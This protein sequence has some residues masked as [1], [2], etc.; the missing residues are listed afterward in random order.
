MLCR[1]YALTA[2]AVFA[3]SSIV[4]AADCGDGCRQGCGRSLAFQKYDCSCDGC[5]GGWGSCGG[6]TNAKC[7][8]PC[9]QGGCQGRCSSSGSGGY[10]LKGWL[11][12]TICGCYG[13][14]ELYWSEW[15]N[16]P[17]P[18]CDPCDWYGNVVGRSK[19]GRGCEAYRAPYRLERAVA[20]QP[21]SIREQL[22]L[23]EGQE[24]AGEFLR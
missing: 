20:K 23:A 15:H 7:G 21:L 12:R 2:A 5:C 8:A 11:G 6:A 17:P 24:A 16:D 10:G 14:G 4:Q 13:C 22:E 1:I 18:V 19:C 3:S 9:G